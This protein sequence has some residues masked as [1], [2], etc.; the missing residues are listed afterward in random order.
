MEHPQGAHYMLFTDP[1]TDP[2]HIAR[3]KEYRDC[4]MHE[5]GPPDENQG[6]VAST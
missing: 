5:Y 1:L 3:A 4:L 2:W 6:D